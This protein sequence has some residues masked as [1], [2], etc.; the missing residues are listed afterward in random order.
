MLEDKREFDVVLW[1]AT[2]FTGQLVAEY[3]AVKFRGEKQSFRWAIAGR[4]LTKLEALRD[5]LRKINSQADSVPILVGNSVDGESLRA[6]ARRTKV[7]CS[8]VGPYMQYGSLL[9]E[10]C[11]SGGADYCDLTGEVPFIRNMIDAHDERAKQ[12]GRKIVHCCGFDSIP[13]DLGCF[14]LQEQAISRY[15]R[16]CPSVML[17][18]TKMKGGAS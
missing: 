5:S 4:N 3:L 11:I 1:G 9:V 16:P 7:V 14:I 17:Y 2:G 6:I 18:V 12:A 15:G 10:A 13:S 8:T